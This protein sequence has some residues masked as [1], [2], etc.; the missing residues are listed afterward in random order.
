MRTC[1]KFKSNGKCPKSYAS[2]NKCKRL[3]RS[4]YIFIS[5]FCKFLVFSFQRYVLEKLKTISIKYKLFKKNTL[6]HIKIKLSKNRKSPKI[7]KLIAY[8]TF[9]IVRI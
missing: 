2:L 9:Y 1:K 7:K 6:K 5:N 3:S 4:H 8:K